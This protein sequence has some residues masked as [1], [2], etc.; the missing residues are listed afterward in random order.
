MITNSYI[1]NK[2]CMLSPTLEIGHKNAVTWNRSTQVWGRGLYV[3]N[4]D[5]LLEVGDANFLYIAAHASP[6]ELQQL[7]SR[8]SRS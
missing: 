4:M 5:L 1:I 6:I 2:H 8:R 7:K 3:A